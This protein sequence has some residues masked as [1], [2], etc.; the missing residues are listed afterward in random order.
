MSGKGLS[1]VNSLLLS[2]VFFPIFLFFRVLLENL[3]GGRSAS[4]ITALCISKEAAQAQL[5]DFFV[6]SSM[7]ISNNVNMIP[8]TIPHCSFFTQYEHY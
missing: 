6:T 1:F 8:A 3:G 4:P 7:D 2:F 5:V